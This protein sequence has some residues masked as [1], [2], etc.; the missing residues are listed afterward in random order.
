MTTMRL[1]VTQSFG[2][3]G[4]SGSVRHGLS[5]TAPADDQVTTSGW[6]E[7]MRSN[8]SSFVTGSSR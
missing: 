5:D 2:S 7:R 8:P 1:A 3:N 6:W 4:T